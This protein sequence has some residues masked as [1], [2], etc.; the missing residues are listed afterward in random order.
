MTERRLS[1][2]RP[3]AAIHGQ[4]RKGEKEQQQTVLPD[5]RLGLSARGG[6]EEGVRR[7]G[8]DVGVPRTAR[9]GAEAP[10]GAWK[11][12]GVGRTRGRPRGVVLGVGVISGGGAGRRTTGVAAGGGVAG[13]G[14]GGADGAAGAGIPRRDP[15]L[16]R[17]GRRLG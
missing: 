1:E 14:A 17:G 8:L 2:G 16:A 11:A 15:T 13:A 10:R 6:A 3:T 5:C 7:G 4:L 12:P 9:E